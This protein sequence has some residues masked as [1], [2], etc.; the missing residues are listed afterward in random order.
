MPMAGDRRIELLA[1]AENSATTRTSQVIKLFEGLSDEG[2]RERMQSLLAKVVT[3]VLQMDRSAS[4][5]HQPLHR[6][7]T[8]FDHGLE[9]VA[10]SRRRCG[11]G[12][13]R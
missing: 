6:D 7:R 10:E 11:Y 1:N 3:R 13:P 12:Y 2:R 9:I 5:F 4:S 8:G